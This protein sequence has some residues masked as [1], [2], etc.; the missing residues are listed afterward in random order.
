MSAGLLSARRR[1]PPL[2]LVAVLLLP[3]LAAVA[4]GSSSAS[5][6]PSYAGVGA[7]VRPGGPALA[8]DVARA[9]RAVTAAV[10]GWHG[11][12]SVVLADGDAAVAADEL[13]DTVR[14]HPDAWATLSA[15]GRQAVLTHELVHVATAAMTTPRTP[16]WLVEGLAE[17]VAWR[18]VA[19]P[20]RVVAQELAAEVRAGRVPGALPTA[21][22]FDARPAQ[23]YQEAWLAVDLLL[24]ALGPARV[25][26]LYR[27][28]GRAPLETALRAAGG[29]PALMSMT[30]SR[31][32]SRD[33][34]MGR[35]ADPRPGGSADATGG[36]ITAWRAELVRRL[37]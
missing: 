30:R 13:G 36:L 6:G 29:V 24:R 27:E 3:P 10:P 5:A 34:V 23:A 9:C 32:A 8:V 19:L 1:T 7:C 28:A 25:L 2:A 4:G 17:A 22:D 14:V 26:E 35:D 21:Q 33:L 11:R 18:D 37:G 12:A 15:Q 20:D 31:H 16:E